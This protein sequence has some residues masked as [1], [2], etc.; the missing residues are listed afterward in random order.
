MTF[1]HVGIVQKGK[2]GKKS[3]R[4]FLHIKA[5][6]P[7]KRP[8]AEKR[9]AGPSIP[10]CRHLDCF[11]QCAAL[12]NAHV[13]KTCKCKSSWGCSWVLMNRHGCSDWWR[14][15]RLGHALKNNNVW[16]DS[17]PLLMDLACATFLCVFQ[18][19]S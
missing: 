2:K 18:H 17:I 4:L 15:S 9:A 5:R 19:T 10:G 6:W 16:N 3:A 13:E 8:R 14:R 11:R 12:E 1:G 7:L